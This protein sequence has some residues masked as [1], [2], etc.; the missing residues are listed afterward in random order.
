[1]FWGLTF[2]MEQHTSREGDHSDKGGWN[3]EVFRS[4][5]DAASWN[6]DFILQSLRE[7]EEEEH[8]STRGSRGRA[9]VQFTDGKTEA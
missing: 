9:I 5:L 8:R 7:T 2:E 3:H 6:S 4:V 1:M